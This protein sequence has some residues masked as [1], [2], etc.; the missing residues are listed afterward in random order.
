MLRRINARFS[1]L[2]RRSPVIS[3]V[4]VM[5]IGSFGH[6]LR[7]V[8]CPQSNLGIFS[9]LYSYGRWRHPRIYCLWRLSSCLLFF[10][11][12]LWWFF[13][14]LCLFTFCF[15]YM[16]HVFAVF[17]SFLKLP[18]LLFPSSSRLAVDLCWFFGSQMGCSRIIWVLSRIA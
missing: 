14:F 10:R 3:L 6:I 2:S 16:L 9:R 4:P 12:G 17:S 8:S 1:R 18:F 5:A 15:C 11:V 7:V 13:I